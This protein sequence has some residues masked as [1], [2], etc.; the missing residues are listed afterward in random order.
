[1]TTPAPWTVVS[2]TA[3]DSVPAVTVAHLMAWL[4]RDPRVDL[5]TVLWSRGHNSP[6]RYDFGRLAN[7]AEAHD[8]FPAGLLRRVGLSRVG[9][10]LAGRA[11]RRTLRSVPAEGVLYLSSAFAAPVLRYLPAGERT[12]VT[13]LH[14]IDREAVPPLSQERVDQIRAVTDVWL[15]VDEKTRAW[16]AKAWEI[17][18]DAIVVVPGANAQVNS[19][20]VDEALPHIAHADMALLQLEIPMDTVLYVAQA[21]HRRGIPV[22][23]DPAPTQPLPDSLYPLLSCITPNRSELHLL[24]GLPTDSL[25]QVKKAAR[26]L[27][28]RGARAVV[29][30]LGAAGCLYMDEQRCLPVPGFAVQVVDTTAAGDSFN[31][32]LAYALAEGQPME[33]ALRFANAVGALSTTNAGAQAAMPTLAQVQALL[34]STGS[35]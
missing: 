9:G 31:A 14:G 27:L 7:V 24:T 34:T 17:D 35:P 30:K 3:D 25:D 11:V 29:A 19:A 16:A 1:M 26:Q 5:H 2:H 28:R 8:V 21:L 20:C 6:Q 33:Q 18:P 10:V 22:M 23:L 4:D 32:G 15:A 12:V 13:H